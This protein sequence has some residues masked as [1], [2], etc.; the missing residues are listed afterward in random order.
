[1]SILF[2]SIVSLIVVAVTPMGHVSAMQST[3]HH[4]AASS[5]PE[6]CT[7]LCQNSE[8]N[9]QNKLQDAD[10][11]EDDEPQPPYYLQFD[12]VHSSFFVEK[13]IASQAIH[14]PDKIPKYRLCC[15]IRR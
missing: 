11:E 4:G 8:P 3:S 1:M 12:S 9:K 6:H 5:M 2:G 15:V 13:E 14:I 10:P 7:M